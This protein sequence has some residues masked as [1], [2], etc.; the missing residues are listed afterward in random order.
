[1]KERKVSPIE[2]RSFCEQKKKRKK[3]SPISAMSKKYAAFAICT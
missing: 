2:K 1:M 3:I